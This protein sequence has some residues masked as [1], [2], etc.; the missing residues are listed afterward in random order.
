MRERRASSQLNPV[1][2]PRG[3][4]VSPV[5]RF[6]SLARLKE[7]S[8]LALLLYQAFLLASAATA[9][10]VLQAP[11]TFAFFV[12][13]L[14]AALALAM[15]VYRK[16]SRAT[17]RDFAPPRALSMRAN[18][19]AETWNRQKSARGNRRAK[20]ESGKRLKDLRMSGDFTQLPPSRTQYLALRVLFFVVLNF[21]LWELSKGIY[22]ASLTFYLL[23]GLG[24]A[25]LSVNVYRHGEGR[26]AS[27]LAQIMLLAVLVKFHFFYLNPYVYTSDPFLFY[28]GLRDLQASGYIP[29]SLG[30]YFYFPALAS[31]AFAGPTL[32]S[33]PLEYYG[34]FAFVSQVAMIP[35]I[36]LIGRHIAEPRLGLLAAL[37][38]VFWTFGFLWTHYNPT[39]FGMLFLFLA[40]YS[41]LRIGKG[42]QTR[43]YLL[44]WVAALAAL[45]SHPINALILVLVLAVRLVWSRV[46]GRRV[47]A[48][49]SMIAPVASYGIVCGSYLAFV[50]VAA[51]SL[52]IRTLFV[53]DY[54]PPLATIETEALAPSFLFVLQSAVA[55]V[56][57][58]IPLF[59]A[60]YAI[61]SSSGIARSE[62]GFLVLLGAAFLLLP[63]LEIVAENFK[64]QGSRML[65][66][67]SIPLVLL[68][69]H[70]LV[71]LKRMAR[72]PRRTVVGLFAIFLAF[73]FLSSTSYLTQNDSR[74]L[75]TD[76]PFA[77]THIT[78]SALSGRRFLELSEDGSRIFL[79]LASLR[80]FGDS[81]RTR[82]PLRG[83]ETLALSAF[84]ETNG[85]GFVLLNDHYLAYGDPRSG[86]FYDPSQIDKALRHAQAILVYD[87]G[88]VRVYYIP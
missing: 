56:S 34:A 69:A 30:H 4:H 45:F 49:R 55:P 19:V 1:S 15:F 12:F 51:F 81:G 88:D 62:H 23:V 70:G 17:V 26:S 79:D 63:G 64:L 50:A 74:I 21:A 71:T 11:S 53:V 41:L 83:Y 24:A 57:M 87:A 5:R 16:G 28:S 75:Y 58:A 36:Y 40:V 73:A 60:G 78:E 8:V 66:Y 46:A 33:A 76:V 59:F 35:I 82:Y 31:F 85:H 32:T 67:L 6:G 80:Y 20:V 2:I 52:F 37:F 77:P 42:K 68:A 7:R 27:L 9:W 39:Q 47:T 18:E 65:V 38:G 25:I 84:N 10:R 14:C 43:W 29:P 3:T 72:S 86:T 13:E 48:A 44:F 54:E 61:L 22:T